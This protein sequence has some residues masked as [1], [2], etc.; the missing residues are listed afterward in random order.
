MVHIGI[1]AADDGVVLVRVGDEILGRYRVDFVGSDRVEL[2]DHQEDK[3]LFLTL[4]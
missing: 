4:R 3:S 1:L 2:F